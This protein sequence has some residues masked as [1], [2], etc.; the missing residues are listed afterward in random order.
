M[1]A[2]V[3]YTCKDHL[4]ERI[5]LGSSVSAAVSILDVDDIQARRLVY[6]WMVAILRTG[7][8]II[9]SKDDCRYRARRLL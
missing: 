4:L 8:I 6:P 9:I 2:L 7:I 5:D 1:V 3:K